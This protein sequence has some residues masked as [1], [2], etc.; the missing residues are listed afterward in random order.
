MYFYLIFL[1][2]FKNYKKTTVEALGQCI[3]PPRH[4]LPVSR[5]GSM[6]RIATK[7]LSFLLAHCQPSMKFLHKVANKQTDRRTDK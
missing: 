2:V 7:I 5:Y 6:I 4:V 1:N 3:P